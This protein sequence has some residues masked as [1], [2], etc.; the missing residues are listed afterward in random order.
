MR[1]TFRFYR[2]LHDSSYGVV[3]LARHV[4]ETPVKAAKRI[5]ST[6]K[7]HFWRKVIA[8]AARCV[9]PAEIARLRLPGVSCFHCGQ[10]GHRR[11]WCPYRCLLEETAAVA[12]KCVP[13][14]QVLS[15]YPWKPKR[16]RY[17]CH[18]CG[19]IEGPQKEYMPP[20][21]Q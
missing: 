19:Q 4:R 14:T 5:Q 3:V 10:N 8:A 15:K 12:A 18:Y 11:R 2:P 9:P 16:F 13:L 6:F 21:V 17:H 1:A 7:A 20:Q